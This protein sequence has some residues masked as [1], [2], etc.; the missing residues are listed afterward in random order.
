[1]ERGVCAVPAQEEE[2]YPRP[3]ERTCRPGFQGAVSPPSTLPPGEPP[4]AIPLGTR[5][6]DHNHTAQWSALRASLREILREQ[7][8]A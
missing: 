6:G 3:A 7:L 2:A 4:S 5:L 8:G 1:M